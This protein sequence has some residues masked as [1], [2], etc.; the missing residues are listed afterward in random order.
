MLE[1]SHVSVLAPHR[2]PSEPGRGGGIRLMGEAPGSGWGGALAQ[3]RQ[4]S[5]CPPALQHP[6]IWG[7]E[8]PRLHAL[9]HAAALPGGIEVSE[10]APESPG[11]AHSSSPARAASASF[12]SVR[13]ERPTPRQPP[14]AL[15]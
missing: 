10:P 9:P 6:Q 8:W 13:W 4:D 5:R 12:T 7:L 3:P 14:A 2:P 11:W 15:Q 1:K